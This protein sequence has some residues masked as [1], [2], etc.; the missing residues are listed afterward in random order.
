MHYNLG[1]TL[2]DV[3]NIVALPQQAAEAEDMLKDNTQLSEVCQVFPRGKDCPVGTSPGRSRR[4]QAHWQFTGDPPQDRAAHCSLMSSLMSSWKIA[5]C[6]VMYPPAACCGALSASV[7]CA[8]LDR[9]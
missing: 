7:S 5:S 4:S 9:A 2:Q 1:K 6:L 3:E 8:K